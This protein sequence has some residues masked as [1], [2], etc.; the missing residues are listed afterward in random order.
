MPT[1]ELQSLRKKLITLYR[2]SPVD[3]RRNNPELSVAY[4][5][6][7]QRLEQITKRLNEE[8]YSMG[9]PRHLWIRPVVN[10][11]IRPTEYNN[12]IGGPT[13]K[14]HL[15]YME[16]LPI[17]RLR[18]LISSIQEQINFMQLRALHYKQNQKDQ[19][20]QLHGK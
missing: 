18:D 5:H 17:L 9:L 16:L 6:V 11:L 3:T 13:E 8:L 20:N 19:E 15:I 10:S 1:V 4:P 12:L 2:K 7:A 14:L